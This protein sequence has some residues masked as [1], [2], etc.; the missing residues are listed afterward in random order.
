[1]KASDKELWNW[2]NKIRLVIQYPVTIELPY[3]IKIIIG[4]ITKDRNPTYT[5]ISFAF[6]NSDYVVLL[7]RHPRKISQRGFFC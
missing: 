1:M 4:G 6:P 7:M 5:N 3:G 2:Q